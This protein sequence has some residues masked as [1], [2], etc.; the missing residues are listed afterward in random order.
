MLRNYI[1]V[2]LRNLLRHKLYSAIN[3][4]GLAVGMAC[5]IT[6][7]YYIQH[8]LSYDKHHEHAD[9]IYRVVWEDTGGGRVSGSALS[10]P[11]LG[12]SLREVFPELTRVA[13][14]LIGGKPVFR[15]GEKRFYEDGFAFADPEILDV[16]DLPLVA[17]NPETALTEPY[18]VVVTE[19]VARRYFGD[20]SPIG[21]TLMRW[22]KAY[23]VT[24]VMK[25][26]PRSTHLRHDIL[27]SARELKGEGMRVWYSHSAYTYVLLPEGGSPEDIT[28]R[29]P[30]FIKRR[31]ERSSG[32]NLSLSLQPVTDIH[33][34]SD[35]SHEMK[36]NSDIRYLYIFGS[37]A[38]LVLFIACINFINLTTA[39]SSHRT[40]EV[41]VRKVLGARQPQLVRQFLGEAILVSMSAL[42]LALF[43]V[44][45]ALPTI[46]VLLGEQLSAGHLGDPLA[47]LGYAAVAVFVGVA[48]GAY[49]A[50]IL[51]SFRPVKVLRGVLKWGSLNAWLRRGLV[52]TQCVIAIVL[53]VC[54]CVIYQQLD[55]VQTKRLGFTKEKVVVI[56]FG[57]ALGK[58]YGAF[59]NE[60]HAHPNVVSVTSGQTPGA[61]GRR[62]TFGQEDGSSLTCYHY[63]VDY[64][65]LETLGLKLVSGRD[66]SRDHAT[67]PGGRIINEACAKLLERDDIFFESRESI[68]GVVRNFHALSLHERIEPM[69]ITLKPGV[70]GDL[71][72]RIGAGDVRETLSYLK[73]AW[74]RSVKDRPFRFAFLDEQLDRSYRE[75]RKLGRIFTAFAS[76]ALFV[77][78]LGLFGMTCF[79]A[80]SRTREIGIRKAVG[81]SVTSIVSMLSSD[82]LR[83]VVVSNLIAW[84]VA[85]LAMADWLTEF[86]YRIELGWSVFVLA[87]LLATAVALVT[88]GSQAVRA[89]MAN[90]VDALRY[91]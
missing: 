65:Y 36:P 17:G 58:L 25:N 39:R 81:A 42:L 21:E 70:R 26:L 90:P 32:T 86:V 30:D 7:L 13:R 19:E 69:M 6:I 47:L 4:T 87:G 66:F 72:V 51:S 37:I 54:T 9:R 2:A 57:R 5:C 52:V 8:G 40:Q 91:E 84:P 10:P 23:R 77:V 35:L 75:E 88:V 60:L 85:Y 79:A 63:E 83:L 48:S 3:V 12:T 61:V 34:R 74:D 27:A 11:V 73:A 67:D 89:A 59:R 15:A 18:T 29:F 43:L 24:G 56:P 45:L 33:L 62:S 80:E 38:V 31:V 76:V 82:S 22:N 49:S 50:F 20:A 64:D 16:F 53:I 46:S 55:Y 71:Q 41:G 14:F 44:E 1:T 78:C 68:L 28:S